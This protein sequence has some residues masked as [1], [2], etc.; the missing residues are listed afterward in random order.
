MVVTALISVAMVRHCLALE[1]NR[2][3]NGLVYAGSP[4]IS[5]EMNQQCNKQNPCPDEPSSPC[6]GEQY[7]SLYG[8]Q[9]QFKESKYCQPNFST[10]TMD[11]KKGKFKC[12]ESGPECGCRFVVNQPEEKTQASRSQCQQISGS[13]D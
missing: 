5:S 9:C 2:C 12:G 10:V 13:S 4:E 6:S 7:Q 1:S 11:V 3:C 8:G